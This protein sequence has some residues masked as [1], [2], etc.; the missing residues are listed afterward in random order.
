MSTN[1]ELPL[2]KDAAKEVLAA[3][4]KKE[5]EDCERDKIAER[6]DFQCL[7]DILAYNVSQGKNNFTYKS[8]F[9]KDGG[10]MMKTLQQHGYAVSFKPGQLYDSRDTASLEITIPLDTQ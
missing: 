10:Y 2:A 8:K 6:K 7:K 1:D 4:A 3:R 9:V 5:R